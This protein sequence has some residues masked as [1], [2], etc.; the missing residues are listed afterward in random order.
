MTQFPQVLREGYGNFFRSYESSR[1]IYR[2][3]ADEGQKPEIMVIGCC[4]SRAAPEIIFDMEPGDIFVTRNIANQVPPYQPDGHFHA[5]SAALEY[6]VKG[7]KVKHIVV[8]G[9]GRCGGIQAAL[10]SADEEKNKA[11]I[12]CA[13]AAAVK[14]GRKRKARAGA[15]SSGAE[16]KR[17]H[18]D[19]DFISDWMRLLKPAV[20]MLAAN[21]LMTQYERQQALE[22]ISLRFSLE[23]LRT[24]PWIKQAEKEGRLALHAAWFDISSAELWILDES[25]AVFLPLPR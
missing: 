5:T 17:E 1:Q 2:R 14:K 23:N 10:A 9:H 7:L 8:L 20:T 3:L 21:A 25:Q 11:E 19:Y 18:G 22:R 13:A 6:A 24:F 15:K 12:C 4:D 16:A